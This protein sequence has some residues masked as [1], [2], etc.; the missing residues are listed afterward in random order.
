MWTLIGVLSLLFVASVSIKVF[1]WDRESLVRGHVHH[2]RVPVFTCLII[3]PLQ[4]APGAMPEYSISLGCI[5]APWKS[6]PATLHGP[7][8]SDGRHNLVITGGIVGTISISGTENNAT[9]VEYEVKLAT[10][11][12]GLLRTLRPELSS[13]GETSTMSINSIGFSPPDTS[14]RQRYD[15]TVRIP[16]T[17]R[18]LDITT[19]A[20]THVLFDRNAAMLLTLETLT[21]DLQSSD[22]KNMILSH[23]N[24][25]ADAL[26]FTMGGGLISGNMLLVQNMTLR[27]TGYSWMLVDAIAS[28][29]GDLADI[30]TVLR[31][32]SGVGRSVITYRHFSGAA[33]RQIDSAHKAAGGRLDINYSDADFEGSVGISAR[34]VRASGTLR[35][36]VV[37]GARVKNKKM[38]LGRQEGLDQVK[39][40]SPKGYVTLVF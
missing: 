40:E 22:H 34:S 2:C 24:V 15:V 5:D 37:D 1:F 6:E 9:E 23:P 30:P 7:I 18:H 12:E 38:W 10:N 19:E 29:D 14:C 13:R 8:F 20:A 36:A 31:T 35:G 16:P 28:N 4:N 32:E 11:D 39:V 33:H 21:V 27:Q 26:F 3:Q 25:Q 17:V